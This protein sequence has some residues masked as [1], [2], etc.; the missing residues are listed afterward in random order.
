MGLTQNHSLSRALKFYV[1]NESAFGTFVKPAATD[2]VKVLKTEFTHE[3]ER[4]LREDNKSSATRSWLQRIS[5]RATVGWNVELAIVPSG[6]AGTAPDADLLYKNALGT[7]TGGGSYTYSLANSQALTGMT[8]YRYTPELAESVWGAWVDEMTINVQSGE[9]PKVKFS[10]GA[11]GHCLTG[12]STLNGIMSSTATMVVQTVDQHSFST[13]SLIS[14]GAN[15]N[16]AVTV[17]SARPS[18]TIDSSISAA[19][20]SAVA[21]YAPTETTAGSPIAGITGSVTYDSA[22]PKITGLELNLK[23]NYRPVDDEALVEY[24]SDVV[25]GYREVSGNVTL[26]ARKD[27]VRHLAKRRAFGTQ[28]LAVAVGATAG[29]ILTINVPYAELDYSA[30]DIPSGDGD[31]MLTLPFVGLGSSG[32]DELT[33]VFS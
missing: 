26:R 29:S 31:V 1:S 30:I 16:L 20:T 17:D 10:G 12:T 19:D 11:M 9:L 14:V 13:N 21:P 18:F 22:S 15:T 33:L 25:P 6:S 4:K 7:G 27:W 3:R 32:E 8:L 2:A 23:N 24:V 28:S 5:G